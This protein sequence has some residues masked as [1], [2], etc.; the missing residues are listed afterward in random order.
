M[1]TILFDLDGTLADT[2]PDL[3]HALHCLQQER[4]LTPLPFEQVRDHVSHGSAAL[5]TLGFP[6][7]AGAVFDG[8]RERFLEIYSAHLHRESR[9]FP[10]MQEVLEAIESRGMNWGIV[11]NKPAFLTDPLLRSMGLYDR[12]AT[13]ISGDTTAERKPHPM[14]MLLACEQSGSTP[15]QCLYI[16]DAHRDIE[17]G[18]A[19]GMRTLVAR[20]GYIDATQNPDAWGADG[21]IQHPVDIMDWLPAQV[22]LGQAS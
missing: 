17:A 2:A 1:R 13:V 3:H 19:A 8:L 6:E 16:G 14:P 4:G 10:G 7:A 12:A 5:V 20:Y 18:R 21:F 11:T 22:G 9:L 15:E